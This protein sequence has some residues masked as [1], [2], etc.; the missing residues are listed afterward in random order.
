MVCWNFS[1]ANCQ[2]TVPKNNFNDDRTTHYSWN[3]IDVMHKEGVF[4]YMYP[5]V[6]VREF[7]QM[8]KTVEKKNEKKNNWKERKKKKNI[9][10]TPIHSLTIVSYD[11]CARSIIDNLVVSNN[12]KNNSR[13]QLAQLKCWKFNYDI[14]PSTVWK[15]VVC[16]L[17]VNHVPWINLL[18]ESKW[19]FPSK[20]FTAKVIFNCPSVNLWLFTIQCIVNFI[21]WATN[22]SSWRQTAFAMFL[23]FDSF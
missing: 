17:D 13:A 3:W 10:K 20:P 21:V 7:V 12:S 2:K 14:R 19:L 15:C 6:C 5:H 16:A 18:E 1:I 11:M 9:F 4:V 8:A 23:Q 22:M